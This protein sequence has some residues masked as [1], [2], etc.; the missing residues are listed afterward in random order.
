MIDHN[1]LTKEIMVANNP[2][3]CKAEQENGD[4]EFNMSYD[5]ATAYVTKEAR[6]MA[7]RLSA[8]AAILCRDCSILRT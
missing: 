2:S 4:F 5:V 1:N 6:D 7:H 3:T 8:L